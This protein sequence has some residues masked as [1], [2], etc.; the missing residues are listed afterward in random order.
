MQ[1]LGNPR[2]HFWLTIRTAQTAGID[3]GSALIDGLITRDEY[4][5]MI[6]LCRA[7]NAVGPCTLALQAAEMVQERRPP[8]TFC[9]NADILNELARH[10]AP[11]Y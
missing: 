11:A 6:D 1:T 10:E 8:P 4:A 2:R 7:C 5:G 3:L 9:V